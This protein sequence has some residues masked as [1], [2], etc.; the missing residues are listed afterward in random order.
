MAHG[1]SHITK[2]LDTSC[3]RLFYE[4]SNSKCLTF[5]AHKMWKKLAVAVGSRLAVYQI[6]AA[7]IHDGFRLCI[8]IIGICRSI[9]QTTDTSRVCSS[10]LVLQAHIIGFIIM[11]IIIIVVGSERFV[12]PISCKLNPVLIVECEQALNFPEQAEENL[13]SVTHTM[14]PI[15]QHPPRHTYG[16]YLHVDS[17]SALRGRPVEAQGVKV[18]CPNMSHV[19]AGKMLRSFI[20]PEAICHPNC[21]IWGSH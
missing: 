15:A 4:H 17:T 18:A 9:F 5:H 3:V 16:L 13:I 21:L 20:M 11:F 12:T 7:L 8:L 2:G 6:V 1:A 10:F 19:P 14:R